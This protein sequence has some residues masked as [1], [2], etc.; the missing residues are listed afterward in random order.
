MP[1]LNSFMFKFLLPF[2]IFAKRRTSLFVIFV[3]VKQGS[4]LVFWKFSSSTVSAFNVRP[5]SKS[6]PNNRNR[7]G[8][9]RR[10][11]S[12]RSG[13]LTEKGIADAEI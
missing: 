7:A 3:S 9:K 1:F 13:R 6:L 5:Y 12:G 4:I 11:A 10:L 2:Q 8:Q